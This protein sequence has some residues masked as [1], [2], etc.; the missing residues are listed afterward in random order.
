M[1][2][3]NLTGTTKFRYLLE[4]VLNRVIIG[5]QIFDVCEVYDYL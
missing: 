5:L 3:Y 1:N 2:S 4:N